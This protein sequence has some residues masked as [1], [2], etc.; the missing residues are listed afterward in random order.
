MPGCDT[1][2]QS[3]AGGG[4]PGINNKEVRASGMKKFEFKTVLVDLFYD[5]AGSLLFGVGIYTFMKAAGFATGGVSGLA[6]IINHLTGLPIGTMML[7]LNLPIILVSYR[8]LGR[9]F[10]LLSL[11]TMVIQTLIVDLV[12]PHFPVYTGSPLLA[13][14]FSGVLIGAG[15]V[16]I[17]MRG[18]ST[19]GTDF[20]ILPLHKA[21]PHLSVGQFSLMIDSVILLFGALVYGN[22]D[23][24]LYGLISTYAATQVIDRVLYGTGSGKMAF[25]ITTQGQQIAKSISEQTDRGSTLVRARGTF[26][27]EEKDMLLC[28]CSKSQIF[29]VRSAAHAVDEDALVMITEVDEVYGEGFKPPQG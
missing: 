8:T 2:K 19:G 21:M 18:S 27:G 26:S 28:A 12:L 20:L 9:R 4:L 14:L 17:Y 13:A 22:I 11:K 10:L 15:L 24:A 1:M 6:L 3:N 23:A 25:I 16:L 7:V 5:L 29:K